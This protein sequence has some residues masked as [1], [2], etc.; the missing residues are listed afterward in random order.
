[1][2]VMRAASTCCFFVCWLLVVA[3]ALMY[4][5]VV[6]RLLPPLQDLPTNIATGF[7]DVFRFAYMTRD[8]QT[9]K[10]SAA[11]ALSKCNV[12]A[13]AACP[14]YQMRPVPGESNT[15]DERN[16]I[17]TAFRESLATVQRVAD[18]EYFGTAELQKTAQ[19]LANMTASIAQLSDTM[20]CSD[21]NVLYCNIYKAGETVI[22]EVASV[23]AEMDRFR[24]SPAVDNFE[25]QSSWLLVLHALPW[26]LV[27]A[28]LSLSIFWCQGG[29]CC[30]QAGGSV[31]AWCS[32][33][34]F[35]VFWLLTFILM[36][37]VVAAGVV[38]KVGSG[39][40]VLDQL[41]GRPTLAQL[42][43][44]IET[45]FPDFYNVAIADLISAFKAWVGASAI[46]LAVS[47]VVLLHSCCLCCARPYRKTGLV[48]S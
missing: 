3:S 22:S 45:K 5:V 36:F 31:Y 15:T 17:V 32:L 8:A 10:D 39:D 23:R 33:L 43:E 37:V 19:E 38:L 41:R 7:D 42:V 4:H 30:C 27:V 21:S 11:S 9:V 48:E 25:E 2:A 16:A 14:S 29:L 34:P 47:V 1:M 12:V 6:A 35:V 28:M 13:S 40:V 24:D 20:P 26:L 46:M 44:H 18:D